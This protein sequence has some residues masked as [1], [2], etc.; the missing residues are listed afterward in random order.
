[1]GYI[2]VTYND[3]N[4]GCWRASLMI[5]GNSHNLGVHSSQRQAARAV[6]AECR[7]HGIPIKNPEV[8]NGDNMDEEISKWGLFS[9]DELS[10]TESESEVPKTENEQPVSIM[11]ERDYFLD[12]I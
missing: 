12:E 4:Y 1:M 9:E 11:T 6:N 8:D 3:K 5:N 2:G 10:E 7:K